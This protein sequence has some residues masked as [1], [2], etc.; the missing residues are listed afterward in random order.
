MSY[1]YRVCARIYA[2]GRDIVI[3]AQGTGW[4]RSHVLPSGAHLIV[5][6]RFD[7]GS[8]GVKVPKGDFG[9]FELYVEPESKERLTAGSEWFVDYSGGAIGKCEVVEV[10][11]EWQSWQDALPNTEETSMFLVI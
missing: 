1:Y 10:L 11:G 4:R 6:A 7:I 5:A 9:I 3:R 8:R 2:P